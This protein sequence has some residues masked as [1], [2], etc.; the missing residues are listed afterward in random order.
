MNLATTGVANRRHSG[1]TID[2]ILPRIRNDN[3][4]EEAL[5]LLLLHNSCKD[6]TSDVI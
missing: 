2:G 6:N 3:G 5:I 1:R 4:L